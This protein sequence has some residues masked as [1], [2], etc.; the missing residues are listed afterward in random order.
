MVL[1][2][3]DIVSA[4]PAV[5]AVFYGV[6]ASWMGAAGRLGVMFEDL[7]GGERG[8]EKKKA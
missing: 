3:G 5:A 4:A 8:K 2:F 7:T 6:L 1:A